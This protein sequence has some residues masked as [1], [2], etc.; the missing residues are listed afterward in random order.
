MPNREVNQTRKSPNP[1][2]DA[3]LPPNAGT[4]VARFIAPLMYLSS[5]AV[6]QPKL[7]GS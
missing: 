4:Y 7:H 2:W 5:E 6:L 1:A 3:V